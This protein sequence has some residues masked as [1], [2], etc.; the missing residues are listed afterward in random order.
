MRILKP[1]YC[2]VNGICSFI[3]R[4]YYYLQNNGCFKYVINC[5][6]MYR[7]QIREMIVY[8]LNLLH[9]INNICPPKQIFEMKRL[10]TDNATSIIS[11][12]SAI[13]YLCLHIR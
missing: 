9:S 8:C 10:N 12:S 2:L 5:H 1:F 6:G 13:C 11:E 3:F 7:K 4:L